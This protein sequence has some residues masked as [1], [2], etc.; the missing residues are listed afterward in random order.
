MMSGEVLFETRT[1]NPKQGDLARGW[2]TLPRDE[3]LRWFAEG[4]GTE[5]H[6]ERP[7][8]YGRMYQLVRQHD[9]L[10][11]RTVDITFLESNAEAHSFTFGR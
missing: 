10:R 5:P 4:E 1:G 2:E 3:R 9:R 6:D 7:A 8:S 11:Q